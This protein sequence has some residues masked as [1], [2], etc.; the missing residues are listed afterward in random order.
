MPDAF[1]QLGYQK[2]LYR[3]RIILEEERCPVCASRRAVSGL[4]GGDM[5]SKCYRENVDA[6]VCISLQMAKE[7]VSKMKSFLSS[8]PFL[9][10]FLFIDVD[11]AH[12]PV[13][14]LFL[15]TTL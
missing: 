15:V 5:C 13:K 11:F 1:S 7:Q 14:F 10:P 8:M 12:Q 2:F 6:T 3:Y 4:V 9:K